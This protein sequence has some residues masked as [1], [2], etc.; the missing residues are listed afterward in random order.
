MSDKNKLILVTGATGYIG[1][2]LIPE[3][4]KR[5]WRVRA[6]ARSLEKLKARSWASHPSLEFVQADLFDLPSMKRACAGCSAAFYLVHS[7]NPSQKDFADAD[8]KASRNMVEAAE[9]AGLDRILYLG[10]LG[11]DQP[12]LSEHLRSRTEVAKILQSG[13]VPVTVLRA[14]MIIGSGSASF[15]IL[16]YLVDRLP[17]MVTPRWVDT[18]SQPIGIRNVIEYLTACL[19]CQETSGQSFDIGGPE[20]ITYR[21]LMEI[22]AQEAGL[23]KRW[24]VP[25]PVLT[26][27]L[28]SYWIHLV[29]P[30]PAS[31]ARPLAEGLRNPVICHDN[32][33]LTMIPQNLLTCR[34][35]VHLALDQLKSDQVETHWTDAGKL[36]PVE[37]SYEGDASWAG[38][39]I[40]KDQR[41]ILVHAPASHVW[42]IVSGVGGKTG[43]YHAD[44]LWKLRGGL[45]KLLGGVGLRRGRRGLLSIQ[46][47]DSLDFWRVLNLRSGRLLLL[48]AEMKLPGKAL[49][50]F[51]VEPVGA[52]ETRL[53]QT[54][55]FL[56]RG[57]M[58]ILYW[59][60]LKPAHDYVF[61]GMNRG[62]ARM[63]EK[64]YA[65]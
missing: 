53:I 60:L 43:W 5:G 41:S 59:Y 32:R 37:W 55:R 28:S 39:T 36:P 26:P 49:L 20:V 14:A 57:L 61:A 40:L 2:R 24:I 29:T 11:E 42:E 6:A 19:E 35:A 18:P 27:R 46:V 17:M 34:E 23:S 25:V 58:G 7:M 48:G 21:K 9:E 54:A 44:M 33:I 56:P 51:R 38:G 8:R 3:L 22:Y 15:E 1:G 12:D 13:K 16:R 45:D 63:A 62:M 50:E 10:G 47:G 31:L 4:L 52:A 30:I 65:H 64:H